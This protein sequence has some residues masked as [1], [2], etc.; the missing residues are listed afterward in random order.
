V[1]RTT[2]IIVGAGP[3]GS[4]C[5]LSL[6]RKGI[7]CIVLERGQRPG[8]KNVASFVLLTDVLKHLIPDFM[9]DAPLE[10]V[11]T[12]ESILLLG[13]DDV[14]NI[15]CRFYRHLR[16][17]SAF[18]AYR[19]KFDAWLASKAEEAGAQ[20]ITGATV[21]DLIIE[22]K[23]VRGVRVGDDELLADVVIGAN[24]VNSV[25][26]E[27]SGLVSRQDTSM[28]ML[29]IKEVLDLPPE[30]IEERF[31]LLQNEGCCYTG[32][33]YPS[34]DVGGA[35]TLYTNR[36][37]ISLAIFGQIH[38]VAE[39]GVSLHSKYIQLK[40]HPFI[41]ACLK[42]STLREYQA[43]ILSD[44]GRIRLKDTVGN[45]VILC[46]DAGGFNNAVYVGVP[47]GMACGM[48]AAEATEL[49]AQK[50]DF[51]RKSLKQYLT[52]MK[53]KTTLVESHGQARKQSVWFAR[54]RPELQQYR[55][56]I[57][58]ALDSYTH[59]VSTFMGKERPSSGGILYHGMIKDFIPAPLRWIIS[60][61][62]KK[63]K[64]KDLTV[65][66]GRG[67]EKGL[68]DRIGSVIIRKDTNPHI[69][70]DSS[71][72]PE[73]SNRQCIISCPA[74]NYEWNEQDGSIIFNHEGCLECGT[75]RY[76]CDSVEWSYPLH[77]MGVRFRWG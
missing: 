39:G 46:G 69:T 13:K 28:Y 53:K 33:G 6:A 8:E 9:D 23:S 59:N 24:G 31:N 26:A 65:D 32:I 56:T 55:N 60:P 72:C 50:N 73:C 49:A 12:E 70:V 35:I 77:G 34:D 11:V 22:D 57:A 58:S 44:G 37:S 17:P 71:A 63:G 21:T 52:L 29:A 40:E 27:K 16:D 10:R 42:G 3:A 51:Q 19:G 68:E 76:I 75:C 66:Y 48:M 20:I 64:D 18:T 14:V 45:G 62:V 47:P 5:A 25:V 30:T 54:R 2:A 4:A 61:F 38:M 1:N 67:S 36:D 15:Q 43:H 7:E 41:H 74:G